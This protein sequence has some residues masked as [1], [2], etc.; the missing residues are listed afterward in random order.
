MTLNEFMKC[1][2]RKNRIEILQGE[3]LRTVKK[4]TYLNKVSKNTHIT[5]GESSIINITAVRWRLIQ[6][7]IE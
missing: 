3:E 1:V 5:Y 4:D 7:T 6:V 2:D